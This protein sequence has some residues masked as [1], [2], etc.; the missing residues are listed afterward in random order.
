ME[1]IL[2]CSQQLVIV[3][4]S[5]TLLNKFLSAYE[6][7]LLEIYGD[8]TIDCCLDKISFEILYSKERIIVAFQPYKKSLSEFNST[9]NDKIKEL[10]N[11][12]MISELI[13]LE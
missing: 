11:I 9:I 13:T 6:E 10:K 8:K 3:I 2:K 12:E 1:Q 4:Q 5:Q 7:T